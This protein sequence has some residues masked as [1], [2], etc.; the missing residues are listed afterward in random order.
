MLEEAENPVL[1]APV[2]VAVTMM[3]SQDGG[4]SGADLLGRFQLSAGDAARQLVE[5]APH[6]IHGLDALRLLERQ[7]LL[8]MNDKHADTGFVRGD[9]LNQCLW[10]VSASRRQ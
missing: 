1:I 2:V 6:A 7:A 8:G 3:T 10:Q 5:L 4:G 9:F